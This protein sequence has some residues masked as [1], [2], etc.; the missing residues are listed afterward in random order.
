MMPWH[1]VYGT[2]ITHRME[3]FLHGTYYLVQRNPLLGGRGVRW[4][5]G[6][7]RV[8]GV[9]RQDVWDEMWRSADRIPFVSRPGSKCSFLGLEPRP[10]FSRQVSVPLQC[11]ASLLIAQP[12]CWGRI[13]KHLRNP[14]INSKESIPPAY[15]A[16]LAGTTTLFLLGS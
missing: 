7:V 8:K 12:Q 9:Y 6:V 3:G 16:W 14:R 15:V 4:G 10:L 5:D 13:F 11:S 1:C 2:Y